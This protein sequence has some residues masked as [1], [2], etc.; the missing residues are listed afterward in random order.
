ML[1]EKYGT[2]L[3]ARKK[4]ANTHQLFSPHLANQSFLDEVSAQSYAT[5]LQL[6]LVN[7]TD[8]DRFFEFTYLSGTK[9]MAFVFFD[10]GERKVAFGKFM[11]VKQSIA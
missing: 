8:L 1:G 10:F 4:Q 3:L 5:I 2:R 6:K 7:E 11:R 9:W